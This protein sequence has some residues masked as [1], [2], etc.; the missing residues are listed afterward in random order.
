M[1]VDETSG[2]TEYRVYLQQAIEA[3][4]ALKA[5]GNA[6]AVE[7]G[8]E[9]WLRVVIRINVSFARKVYEASENPSV[10]RA[11]PAEAATS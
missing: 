4:A 6:G 11:E 2:P 5:L 8:L 10:D 1:N 7:E 9:E 3:S